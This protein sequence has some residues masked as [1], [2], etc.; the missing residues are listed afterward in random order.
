MKIYYRSSMTGTCHDK[1]EGKYRGMNPYNVSGV[2]IGSCACKT[3]HHFKSDGKD[4]I[5]EY[6]ECIYS[7]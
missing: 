5:G 3:C 1:C 4:D 2:M 7:D 6:V